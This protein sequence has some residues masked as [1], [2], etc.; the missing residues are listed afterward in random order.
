MESKQENIKL[1]FYNNNSNDIASKVNLKSSLVV[2]YVDYSSQEKEIDESLKDI[3][4]K[5]AIIK[6]KASKIMKNIKISK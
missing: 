4:L 1:R 6:E 3:D 5:I 2:G